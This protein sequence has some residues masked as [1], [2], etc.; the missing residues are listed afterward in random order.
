MRHLTFLTAFLATAAMAEPP[1][2]VPDGGLTHYQQEDCVDPETGLAG[3]CFY[4]Y[5]IKNNRYVAFYVGDLAWVIWQVVDGQRVE[6][7]RR[8][9]DV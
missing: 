7:W 6:I 5:D 2:P 1:P 8:G 9:A 4:S 3:R